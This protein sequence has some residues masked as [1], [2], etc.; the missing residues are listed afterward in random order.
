MPDNRPD[1]RP[2]RPQAAGLAPAQRPRDPEAQ[3]RE[4]EPQPEGVGCGM[5]GLK[6]DTAPLGSAPQNSGPRLPRRTQGWGYRS[7]R[8]ARPRKGGVAG[9][10]GEGDSVEARGGRGLSVRWVGW[11]A[12]PGFLAPSTRS[13]ALG[14]NHSAPPDP[15]SSGSFLQPHLDP[16]SASSPHSGVSGA[17]AEGQK[18]VLSQ[19]EEPGSL[20]LTA[21]A[22]R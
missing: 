2:R 10:M 1:T 3:R 13:P 12:K 7:P 19:E 11:L 20:L 15:P 18:A 9:G 4:V 16:T 22:M 21:S 8:L 14:S 5:A 17:Q 6:P